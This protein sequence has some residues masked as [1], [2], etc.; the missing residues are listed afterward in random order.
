MAGSL[1]MEDDER[2]VKYSVVNEITGEKMPL[3][4]FIKRMM[5]EGY[6]VSFE[7]KDDE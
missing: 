1:D 3:G 5:D 6:R 7:P 2:E 4:D